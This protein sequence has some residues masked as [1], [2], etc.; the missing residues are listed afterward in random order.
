MDQAAPEFSSGDT[1]QLRSGGPAMTVSAVSQSL[2]YCVWF[3]DGIQQN[4][5][6]EQNLLQRVAPAPA[7]PAA[8]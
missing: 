5:T 2:A 1:V 8:D 4:G 7:D 3:S 6:F